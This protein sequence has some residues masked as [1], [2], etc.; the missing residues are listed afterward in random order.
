MTQEQ[1]N[2]KITERVNLGYSTIFAL[3]ML[4]NEGEKFPA[5][6]MRLEHKYLIRQDRPDLTKIQW[7]K[8]HIYEQLNAAME[9]KS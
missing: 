5:W 4:Y 9:N 3:Y 8:Q 7:I 1:F 6:Y 2:Q